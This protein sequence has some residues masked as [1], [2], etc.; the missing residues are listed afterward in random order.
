MMTSCSSSSFP[1]RHV[2]VL[3]THAAVNSRGT[4][5]V[6]PSYPPGN[7]SHPTSSTCRAPAQMAADTV[8]RAVALVGG[9]QRAL[10]SNSF[11]ALTHNTR[12]LADTLPRSWDPH[13]NGFPPPYA[14]QMRGAVLTPSSPHT[15][16]HGHFSP[17][18]LKTRGH[19]SQRHPGASC[20]RNWRAHSL[21]AL[22]AGP[23][24][25][26]SNVRASP[27]LLLRKRRQRTLPC[28]LLSALRALPATT[29]SPPRAFSKC[30]VRLP[31][32]FPSV[33]YTGEQCA[34][35]CAGSPLALPIPSTCSAPF[36]GF[37]LHPRAPSQCVI[38]GKCMFPGPQRL[39]GE[40]VSTYTL[41]LFFR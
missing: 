26:H 28:C 19:P 1:R 15:F 37:S 32:S 31:Q 4:R 21:T 30:T 29:T 36:S 6:S 39:Q 23:L 7:S 9:R 22:L 38:S 33:T 5:S 10:S 14:S 2:R 8:A 17:R 41:R 11:L 20:A 12:G 13:S 40:R 18:A 24:H 27:Q 3:R 16:R 35:G 34:L 25:A